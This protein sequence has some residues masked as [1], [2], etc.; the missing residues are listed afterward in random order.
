MVTDDEVAAWNQLHSFIGPIDCDRTEK[1]LC[2]LI[3]VMRYRMVRPYCRGHVIDVSCGSGYG[4]WMV[5]LNPDVT[6]V[7]GLDSC[8]ESVAFA[9]DSYQ[10]VP[11]H[12]QLG[13]GCKRDFHRFDIDA[14]ILDGDTSLKC[15][16]PKSVGG[17]G[18]DTVLS[19]ETVEHLKDPRGF[20]V[21]AVRSG[22][23]RLVL[24]FPGYKTTHYNPHHRHD[25]EKDAVVAWVTEAVVPGDPRPRLVR[26]MKPLDDFY[27]LVF[28]LA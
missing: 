27:L 13:R 25:L 8:Q 24:T 17:V 9:R 28:D 19:V 3:E 15:G 16:F 20:L 6:R 5:S 7:T 22:A 21:N 2:R 26:C 12:P 10:N 14:G 23:S 1:E 4:S 11:G 18:V